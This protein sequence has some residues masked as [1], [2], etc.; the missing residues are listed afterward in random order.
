MTSTIGAG[1]GVSAVDKWG[2]VN[3]DLAP[4]ANGAAYNIF[5]PPDG[6]AAFIHQTTGANTIASWTYIDQALANG[7]PEALV[8]AMHN[9]S[10]SGAP[11]DKALGVYYTGTEWAIF[12]QDETPMPYGEGFNVFVHEPS[13]N[14]F[15]HVADDDNSSGFAT[16]LDHPLANGRPEAVIVVTQL[17]VGAEG[18]V[19]NP[20]PIG[21]RYNGGT[22]RWFIANENFVEMPLGAQFNVL[23]DGALVYLP[24]IKR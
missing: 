8:F 4:M 17:W 3:E 9:Q 10:I 13:P 11:L 20:Q 12:T 21:I 18:A 23:I 6:P 15:V 5:V 1:Y 14:A 2:V 16:I 24:L 7:N 19:Y 22:D